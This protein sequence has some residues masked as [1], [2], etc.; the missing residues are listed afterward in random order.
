MDKVSVII[1]A[2]N[3]QKYIEQCVQSV[4]DQTY[5][6]LEIIIVNDGSS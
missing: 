2:Y 3:N 1:T 5:R 6:N 4:I